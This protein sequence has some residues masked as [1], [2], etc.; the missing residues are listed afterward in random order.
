ASHLQD[1]QGRREFLIL[2]EIDRTMVD[3]AQLLPADFDGAGLF[4]YDA[5]RDRIQI[6]APMPIKTFAFDFAARS[7][8]VLTSDMNRAYISMPTFNAIWTVDG[9]ANS[10]PDGDWPCDD[11][12]DTGIDFGAA[13][14]AEVVAS[15]F[16]R[17]R[18]LLQAAP[19]VVEFEYSLPLPYCNVNDDAVTLV[20]VASGAVVPLADGSVTRAL[21]GADGI[22]T[23]SRVVITLPANL[24]AGTNYRLTLSGT[25]LGAGG[26]F[27][28]QF[29]LVAG[30]NFLTETRYS[31]GIAVDA[32]GLVYVA[33]EDDVYGPFDAPAEVTS[34][35]SLAPGLLRVISGG[36]RP[37]TT[38]AAGNV[39]L[40]RRTPADVV[41]IDPA[42][43]AVETLVSNVTGSFDIDLLVAP[44][45]F[46][47]TVATAGDIIYLSSQRG[48]V[49]DIGGTGS[50]SLFTNSVGDEYRNYFV[51]PVDLFGP[52]I[53]GGFATFDTFGVRMITGDG[54]QAEVFTPLDGVIGKGVIRLQDNTAGQTEWLMLAD[55]V[56]TDSPSLP[57]GQL[58]TSN[59]G[60]EL[61][62][63][64]SDTNTIQVLGFMSRGVETAP[65]PLSV[66]ANPDFGFTG[67]L[68]T[69]YLTQPIA[70]TVV[71]FDGFGN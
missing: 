34:A 69:V 27:V 40:S 12:H 37:I 45:G 28:Q 17:G 41:S 52:V 36:G 18:H 23:G 32:E 56:Q 71:E 22:V 70:R 35:D 9:L 30:S 59:A 55:F 13:G 33:N 57:T 10:N 20:D 25:A 15:T 19:T 1:V 53:Y 21:V 68:E 24:E 51:A 54:N 11:V 48:S 14:S 4:V 6:V 29:Q 47:G 58:R 38:D 62:V 26:D 60:L 49:A 66:N 7:Q 5:T 3:T 44:D 39:L 31:P 42:T 8:A 46:D 65:E 61:L 43:G 63:Y 50:E 2:G 16:G 64:N 67:D